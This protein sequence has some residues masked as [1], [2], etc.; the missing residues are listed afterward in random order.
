MSLS[1]LRQRTVTEF[2]GSGLRPSH[3]AGLK[4]MLG[5]FNQ[6]QI[7]GEAWVD[8]SFLTE[9]P[10]PNDID[11]IIRV[12]SDQYDLGTRGKRDLLDSYTTDDIH[13]SIAELNIDAYL[14][15]EY[16]IDHP[17][18]EAVTK[19]ARQYYSNLYEKYKEPNISSDIPPKGIAVIK[20]L[21][22]DPASWN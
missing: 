6:E 15:L 16:P 13:P 7:E 2:A 12:R 8:G 9:N 19:P 11:V 3:F 4:A 18:F 20:F 10:F 17:L 22:G 5:Q 14:L 1:E 21:S